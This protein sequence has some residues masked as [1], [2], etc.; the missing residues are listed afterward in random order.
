MKRQTLLTALA[1]A[2]AVSAIAGGVAYATI[3]D[4]AGVINGC[5]RTSLDDQRGQLRVVDDPASCRSNEVAIHWN[6]KGTQGIQGIQGETGATGPQG[7][8][9]DKGD[10]GETG[11]AGTNG[12]N[13]VSVTSAAEAAGANCA[14]GG[15]KFTAANG[16]TYACNGAQGPQGPAGPAGTGGAVAWARVSANGTTVAG[17]SGIVVTKIATGTYEVRFFSG[18]DPNACAVLATAA[19]FDTVATTQQLLGTR[20]S[21]T[22]YTFR[23]WNSLTG[24][25]GI[26]DAPFS[27][28]IFC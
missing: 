22:V 6:Q 5:Y 13:G 20:D 11:P 27:T 17:S 25:P 14:N 2:F 26:L 1:S 12:T 15:S 19:T 4:E 16:T 24:S 21:Y 9:G 8:K 10:T 23:D 7:P 3:P 28:A 18:F